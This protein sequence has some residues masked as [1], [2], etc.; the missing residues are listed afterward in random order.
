MGP[1]SLWSICL[2]SR[3]EDDVQLVVAR[4]GKAHSLKGEVVLDVRTDDPDSRLAVGEVLA[5]N[6]AAAGPLTV[7]S[8]RM[9]Q[10]RLLVKFVEAT[11][12]TAAEALRGVELIVD[13]VASDDDD[14]WYPHELAGLTAELLD[15]PKVGQVITL[16]S[17]PAHDLLIIK[18]LNGARTA[19]PFVKA[20]V[21]VVDVAGGRV[22]IDPP[23]GLL[24]AD[25]T[26]AVVAHDGGRQDDQDD[27]AGK[28]RAD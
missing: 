9:H 17:A 26:S 10:G 20:I 27:E 1:R 8:R 13:A 18:E 16:E 2:Y 14:A 15:G 24:A 25:S 4:I 6:P 21:P 28:Y 19:I 22:V 12:R 23:G 3:W 7:L 5:T 11:D